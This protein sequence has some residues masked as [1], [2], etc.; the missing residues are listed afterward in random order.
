[1]VEP[2][3]PGYHEAQAR[4]I[5]KLGADAEFD[6]PPTAVTWP[7]DTALD[8][9]TGQPY[10]PTI[11]PE[12]GGDPSQA[13]VKGTVIERTAKEATELAA[14]GWVENADVALKIRPDDRPAI[15]GATH[16]TVFGERYAIRDIRPS[17]LDTPDGYLVYGAHTG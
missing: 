15:D 7:A 2:N 8:P 14:I 12:S 6:L 16:F 9:E 13:T 11:E 5:E 10:D 3:L 4:L 17:G 1:M